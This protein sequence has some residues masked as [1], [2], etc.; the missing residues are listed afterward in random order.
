MTIFISELHFVTVLILFFRVIRVLCSSLRLC[1]F[2]V[3][4]F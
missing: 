2:A 4:V 1:D 3:K